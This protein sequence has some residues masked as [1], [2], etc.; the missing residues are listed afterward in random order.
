MRS[1]LPTANVDRHTLETSQPAQPYNQCLLMS[2]NS[3]FIKRVGLHN[4]LIASAE[5]VSIHALSHNARPD[6]PA[7]YGLLH[8]KRPLQL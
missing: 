5:Q 8:I 2:F 7:T 4:N 1:F 3:S 6:H